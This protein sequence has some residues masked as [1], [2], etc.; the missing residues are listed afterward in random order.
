[1]SPVAAA[2]SRMLVP[3][4]PR[5]AMRESAVSKMF[6]RWPPPAAG[7]PPVAIPPLSGLG[8]PP[9]NRLGQGR[10]HRTGAPWICG[11]G[12]DVALALRTHR[13]ARP[14]VK[15]DLLAS[16]FSEREQA[17]GRLATLLLD[18][19]DGAQEV[20]REAFR[21]TFSS[22]AQL[23][24]SVPPR[25]GDTRLCPRVTLLYAL[26]PSDAGVG[27]RLGEAPVPMM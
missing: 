13:L 4:T 12:A 10:N 18:D 26:E 23:R 19:V 15:D 5:C 24:R 21:G 11:G 1:L 25:T 16:V 6:C 8:R 22:S 3:D 2:R 7:A 20:L 14:Q 17:R 9:S 27:G